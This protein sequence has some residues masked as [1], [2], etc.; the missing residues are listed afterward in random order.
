MA[1]TLTY[2]VKYH[3]TS[4]ASSMATDSTYT[5]AANSLSVVFV[6]NSLA[7]TPL[8][9]ATVS[10]H[11]ISYTKV[12][13]AS[14]LLSTTH[15]FSVWVAKMGSSPS[16][17]A[18]TADWSGTNQTGGT[19]IEYECTGAE[20]GGTALAAIIQNNVA[21]GTS[22][23]VTSTNLLAA[24]KKASNA[25]LAFWVHLT[26]E[27]GGTLTAGS[28]TAGVALAGFNTPATTAGAQHT[29]G[30]FSRSPQASWTTS[31]AYAVAAVEIGASVDLATQ[32]G[33]SA[34]GTLAPS[35]R[36][37]Q[38]GQEATS[39]R[40]T[41]GARVVGLLSGQGLT[42]AG[43][44][45]GHS[46]TASPIA[47]AATVAEG[48]ITPTVPSLPHSGPIQYILT[49]G[50]Y[51]NDATNSS[52]VISGVYVVGTGGTTAV[53][54]SL[55][56]LAA[57]SAQGSVAPRVAIA[58]TGAQAVV[59]GGALTASS[60]V[61]GA[62]TGLQA[63]AAQGGLFPLLNVGAR[64]NVLA[65]TEQ[66]DNAIWIKNASSISSNATTAPNGTTTADKLVEDSSGSQHA[67]RQTVSLTASTNYT[68]SVFAKAG[69][70]TWIYLQYTNDDPDDKRAW[71]DLGS[72]AVG[73]VT[74]AG[75]TSAITP[76]G[77]GWY[78]CSI[79][80]TSG[81]GGSFLPVALANADSNIVYAG[82]GSSGAYLW[83]AQLEVGALTT[84]QGSLYGA[85]TSGG[86]LASASVVSLTGQ[87]LVS[88][89]GSL[90][91]SPNRSA[92]LAG[93]QAG[94]QLGTLSPPAA[95]VTERDYIL[96][97]G[98]FVNDH[99]DYSYVIAGVYVTGVGIAGASISLNGQEASGQVGAISARFLRA[100]SG[101]EVSAQA[102]SI[103]ASTSVVIAGQ[104]LAAQQGAFALTETTALV[105]QQ[106][107]I[108]L[109][110][111]RADHA[112][113]LSGAQCTTAQGSVSSGGSSVAVAGAQ[114]T[115][116]QGALT[117]A[118]AFGFVGQG[119]TSSAGLVLGDHASA[120]AGIEAATE[121]G[122]ASASIPGGATLPGHEAEVEQGSF[123]PRLQVA[124]D[125]HGA[126]CAQGSLAGTVACSATGQ[127]LATAAGAVNGYTS[128]EFTGQE[129]GGQQGALSVASIVGLDGLSAT[130]QKGL[131]S[132]PGIPHREYILAPGVYLNDATNSSYVIAGIY[133]TANGGS[134]DVTASV[135][136]LQASAQAGTLT[137]FIPGLVALTGQVATGARGTPTANIAVL[138]EQPDIEAVGQQVSVSEGT[139]TVRLA[140][141]LS[142]QGATVSLGSVT[143]AVS[144]GLV[145]QSLTASQ[146]AIAR[147]AS[148]VLTGQQCNTAGGSI[149]RSH[150]QTL[151]GLS[152]S[153][154]SGQITSQSSNT[155]TLTGQQVDTQSGPVAT[156]H[157]NA[158]S[159]LQAVAEQEAPSAGS[160]GVSTL[161]G[162]D[163]SAEVG[164][165]RSDH[166]N[167]IAGLQAGSAQGTLSAVALNGAALA[168]QQ[169]GVQ[170]GQLS[171]AFSGSATL[172]GQQAVVNQGQIAAGA[173]VVVLLT[174]Q[175]I[176]TAGGSLAAQVAVALAGQQ[177]SCQ[178]GALGA[179]HGANDLGGQQ[180]VVEGG[181][182][183]AAIDIPLTENEVELVGLEATAGLGVLKV[184]HL[185]LALVCTEDQAQ[186]AVISDTAWHATISDAA[187]TATIIDERL[188]A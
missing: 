151:A 11:G 10:G 73:S 53:S 5:P 143:A 76:E 92:S 171:A 139:V 105:G 149:S 90:S 68:Y 117:P 129:A 19:I 22:N 37:T 186:T 112:S 52:Y 127:Q 98:I 46:A 24:E 57:T 128:I 55:T 6:C 180:V 67:I 79:T 148:N 114:A 109:G 44:T 31:A 161:N 13:L 29:T 61:S 144:V 176:T 23:N 178:A 141:G 115:V 18:V 126:T 33:T 58:F 183:S 116:A 3:S 113:V 17:A 26:N 36:V 32:A 156:R 93:L 87:G 91:A 51:L 30:T 8:D 165:V 99:N 25:A 27:S 104:A 71:F 166:R 152:A 111:V 135:A 54:V 97:P 43:G 59:S 66:F 119:L 89:Q 20:I 145:G 16:S 147:V 177:A 170:Q 174:G 140:V 108:A 132:I 110:A 100:L 188:C 163:V 172:A 121:Q 21:T 40:G 164:S 162:I 169:A 101:L 60:F 181:S 77:S 49:P 48:T 28:F 63:G 47:Q 136:G 81:P 134:H 131:L 155:G 70:R 82:D 4:A 14:R 75:I 124:A 35:D 94:A 84:Y 175:V 107:V 153:A 160:S 88:A 102:G 38:T 150:Q 2:R 154:Q 78:R 118:S 142:W 64:R 96:A 103:T 182:V 122:D 137:A 80:V 12:T 146:G 167:S 85:S 179:I 9:P 173:T 34:S 158:P 56:G 159:G 130:A 74:G 86:S 7:S 50:L 123:L 185:P 62:L 39:A 168:G 41:L 187:G 106:S 83:G 42:A 45:L 72:G 133:V 138:I 184:A 157:S 1:L 125:G 69:E 15:C 120:L 65:Y 95:V